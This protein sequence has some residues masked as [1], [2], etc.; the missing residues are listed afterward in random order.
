MDGKYNLRQGINIEAVVEANCLPKELK[1]SL[2]KI[3][4][5]D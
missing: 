5:D 1:L 2:S 3:H 4:V